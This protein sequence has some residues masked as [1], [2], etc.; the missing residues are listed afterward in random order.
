MPAGTPFEDQGK[1]ALL[2]NLRAAIVGFEMRR[3]S[4]YSVA[5]ELRDEGVTD[6]CGILR[7]N[8]HYRRSRAADKHAAETFMAELEAIRDAR[9]QRAAIRLM[10]AIAK[11]LWREAAA[12]AKGCR[13]QRDALQILHY[14]L[15]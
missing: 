5:A 7:G 11:E 4:L 10:Y 6:F 13:Q 3:A 2:K 8:R 15:P 14:I 1:P 12:G 9:N